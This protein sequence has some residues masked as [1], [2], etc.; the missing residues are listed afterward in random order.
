[1]E[2]LDDGCVY[3]ACARVSSRPPCFL[4]QSPDKNTH[5]VGLVGEMIATSLTNGACLLDMC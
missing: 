3:D 2:A 5:V 4:S 1:M